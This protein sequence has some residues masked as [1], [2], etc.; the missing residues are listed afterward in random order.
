VSAGDKRHGTW[1]FFAGMIA[2]AALIAFYGADGSSNPK[3]ALGNEG[4]AP[5]LPADHGAFYD[6]CLANGGRR[7]SCDA[8]QVV[9]LATTLVRAFF[10]H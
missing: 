1:S 7:L 8:Q 10:F 4:L 3:R 5:E 9:I 2:G 6:L